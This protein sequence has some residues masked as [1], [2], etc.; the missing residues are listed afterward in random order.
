[1]D[2]GRLQVVGVRW[3]AEGDPSE[4]EGFAGGSAVADLCLCRLRPW[5]G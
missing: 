4:V 2:V 1:L 5:Y 3:F